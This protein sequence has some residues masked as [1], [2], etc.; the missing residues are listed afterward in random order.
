MQAWILYMIYG[1]YAGE[2]AQFQTAREM[3]RQIV[4]VGPKFSCFSS[5][6]SKCAD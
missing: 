5:V 4:D 6:L 2:A 1:V 3:L